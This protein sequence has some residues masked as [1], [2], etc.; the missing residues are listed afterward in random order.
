MN[1]IMPHTLPRN[2]G[3]LPTISNVGHLGITSL[4]YKRRVNQDGV[5]MLQNNLALKES[6]F[7][8]VI[9][10][11]R[12]KHLESEEI[13]A[14]KNRIKAEKKAHELLE[15]RRRHHEELVEKIERQEEQRKM[16]EMNAKK[17]YEEQH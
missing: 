15:A 16:L 11:N 5:R 1:K 9:L 2:V 17:N 7:K 4:G 8:A 14:Q 13:K 10:E 12:L 6:E 3:N